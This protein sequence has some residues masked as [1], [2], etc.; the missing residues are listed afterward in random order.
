MSV[1]HL[2]GLGQCR[3]LLVT[4]GPHSAQYPFMWQGGLYSGFWDSLEWRE[5]GALAL[6]STALHRVGNV[7]ACL[8]EPEKGR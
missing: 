7:K 1:R 2:N 3:A 8:C 4:C 5:A 6:F